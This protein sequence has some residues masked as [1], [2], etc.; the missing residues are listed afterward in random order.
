MWHIHQGYNTQ[1]CNSFPRCC[2]RDG[3]SD[4][5]KQDD[6]WN[7]YSI[8]VRTGPLRLQLELYRTL[9]IYS[10]TIYST[11]M[12][13]RHEIFLLARSVN[14]ILFIFRQPSKFCLT[15]DKWSTYMC[16]EQKKT[17]QTECS[18]PVG[19]APLLYCWGPCF[20]FRPE[21]AI[22][23][24]PVVIFFIIHVKT[25]VVSQNRPRP[26]PCTSSQVTFPFEFVCCELPK[27]SIN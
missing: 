4:K 9:L 12:S 18:G 25:M 5:W 17:C 2:K 21:L 22:L 16:V 8:L 19:S 24:E 3:R 20:I 11:E 10:G 23:S 15:V 27:A 7:M 26:L 14:C 13:K 1:S 6:M